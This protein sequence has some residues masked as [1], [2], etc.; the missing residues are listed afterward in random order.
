MQKY[1]CKFEVI[2]ELME[3]HGSTLE[4]SN[5][6]ENKNVITKSMP[7]SISPVLQTASEQL[8]L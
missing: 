1:T 8:R 6:K 7:L 2:L 5:Q 3:L 4:H